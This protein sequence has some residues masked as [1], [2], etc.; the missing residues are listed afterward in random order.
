MGFWVFVFRGDGRG[1]DSGE[2]RIKIAWGEENFNVGQKGR[3]RFTT[4]EEIKEQYL[5]IDPLETRYPGNQGIPGC[6]D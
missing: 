2:L 5:E 3:Q 6:T 4:P 1:C